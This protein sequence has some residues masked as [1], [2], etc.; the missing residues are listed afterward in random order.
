MK[1]T[2]RIKV[3]NAKNFLNNLDKNPGIKK[4]WVVT[5]MNGTRP[6]FEITK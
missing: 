5:M 6:R 3:E 1:D 4:A 2:N